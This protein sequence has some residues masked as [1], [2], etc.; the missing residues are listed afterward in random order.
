MI[1]GFSGTRQGMT[2]DQMAV[3]RSL[4]MILDKDDTVRH[5]DCVGADLEFHK[6]A[7]SRGVVRIIVHPPIV[8]THRAFVPP[9]Q[10][11]NTLDPAPYLDRN[12]AIVDGSRVLLAAPGSEE[13]QPRG[14][15]WSTV[16]YARKIRVPTIVVS[17]MGRVTTTGGWFEQLR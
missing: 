8:S 16:R 4:V 5:G 7:V 6:M 14:G 10:V 2:T 13:E 1:L 11:Y 17:P 15:T 3:V 9:S 12:K